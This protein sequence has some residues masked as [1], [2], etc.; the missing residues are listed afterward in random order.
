MKSGKHGTRQDVFGEHL[1]NYRHANARSNANATQAYLKRICPLARRH[2][3]DFRDRPRNLSKPNTHAE[4]RLLATTS[5]K[6]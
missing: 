1:H 2:N 4:H 6:A 5:L 3:L